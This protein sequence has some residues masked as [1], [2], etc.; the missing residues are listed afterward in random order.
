LSVFNVSVGFDS[1]HL[2][3]KLNRKAYHPCG[4]LPVIAT[5]GYSS[6]ADQF[7]IGGCLPW[8]E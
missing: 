2:P 3:K 5:A 1:R 7:Q 8:V 6:Q 4:H